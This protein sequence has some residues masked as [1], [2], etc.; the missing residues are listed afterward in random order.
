MLPLVLEHTIP[1]KCF[2]LC[3]L[4]FVTLVLIDCIVSFSYKRNFSWSCLMLLVLSS[5]FPTIWSCTQ[6]KMFNFCHFR[7]QK[8]SKFAKFCFLLPILTLLHLEKGKRDPSLLYFRLYYVHI[9]CSFAL[10]VIIQW[11]KNFYL[12]IGFL[13][14]ITWTFLYQVPLKKVNK[15]TPINF[16][17]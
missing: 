17:I 16:D 2:R 9:F 10:N 13:V 3:Y 12:L 8:L 11:L 5:F 4:L 6:P 15:K 7:V 14:K 1:W